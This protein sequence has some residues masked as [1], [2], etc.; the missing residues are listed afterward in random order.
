MYRV[1]YNHHQ[2][3]GNVMI[4]TLVMMTMML[5]SGMG[6]IKTVV[7]Q[8]R[9]ILSHQSQNIAFSAAESALQEGEQFID[10][11]ENIFLSNDDANYFSW[12]LDDPDDFDP[13]R[14]SAV[15]WSQY[16]NE[17]PINSAV[18]A[19]IIQ[20]LDQR[21]ITGE[22][23]GHGQGDSIYGSTANFFRIGAYGSRP[24]RAR[25]IIDVVYTNFD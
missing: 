7:L 13:I 25:R 16:E 3:S 17:S 6:A 8:Q 14:V 23:L 21:T 18:D 22:E 4:I 9:M 24:D 11:L 2:Q 1:H 19:Y 12:N 5:I 20:L 10:S 15:N